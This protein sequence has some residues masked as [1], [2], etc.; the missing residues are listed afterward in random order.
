VGRGGLGGVVVDGAGVGQQLRGSVTVVASAAVAAGH[1][2]GQH[3]GLDVVALCV[4][5]PRGTVA[6]RLGRAPV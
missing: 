3:T 5:G 4:V 6:V 1:T 2:A